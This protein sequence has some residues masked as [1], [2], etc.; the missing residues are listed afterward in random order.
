MKSP[1][2]GCADRY[3][4]CHASCSRYKDFD[5]TNKVQWEERIKLSAPDRVRMAS[6]I[7]YM[8]KSRRLPHGQLLRKR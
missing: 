7:S 6:C 1:C 5:K 3:I 4:G 8:D 2:L